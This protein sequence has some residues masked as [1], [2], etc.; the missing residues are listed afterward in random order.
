MAICTRH[1]G[2]FSFQREAGL[3]MVEARHPIVAIVAFQAV[4]SE[5]LDVLLEEGE[6]VRSVA[7]GTLFK[8]GGEALI[9]L[10]AGHA[11]HL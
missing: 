8:R 11:V 7:L 2:V 10:M 9:R 4:L 5:V 1:L 3:G 6:V